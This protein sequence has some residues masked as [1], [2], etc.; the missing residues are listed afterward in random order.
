MSDIKFNLY[1]NVKV[2]LTAKGQ[3]HYQQPVDD[4]GYVQIKLYEFIMVFGPS[5]K[6]GRSPLFDNILYLQPPPVY[7]ETT[8]IRVN[9]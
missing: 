6:N 9:L 8:T 5:I 1:W 7:P 2:R 3:E 4:K